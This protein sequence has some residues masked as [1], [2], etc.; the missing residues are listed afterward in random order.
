MSAQ[1][2]GWR[3]QSFRRVGRDPQAWSRRVEANAR[4]LIGG[5]T[6]ARVEPPQLLQR[7][8]RLRT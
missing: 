1:Q 4:Q 3:V 8:S 7:N 2:Q 6:A 5:P